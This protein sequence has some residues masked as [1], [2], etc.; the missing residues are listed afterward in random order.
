MRPR[1]ILAILV[2]FLNSACISN[3]YS[4]KLVTKSKEAISVNDTKKALSLLNNALL[5]NS[6]NGEA[7]L[8]KGKIYETINDTAQ[9]IKEYIKAHKYTANSA[10][11][12]IEIGRLLYEIGR[13]DE[14]LKY[15]TKSFEEDSTNQQTI[16]L[17]MLV[18]S[19]TGQAE[20]AMILFDSHAT[21]D[22]T[23]H[24]YAKAVASDTLGMTDYAAIFY[25][26]TIEKD[27]TN[28]Q[29]YINYSQLLIDIGNDQAALETANEG[30]MLFNNTE[31]I[32]KTL[33]IHTSKYMWH[34]AIADA[35][36]LYNLT[37]NIEYIEKRARYFRYLGLLNNARNDYS[38]IIA[39]DENNTNALF[40]RAIINMR[41][42]NED[43]VINDLN[44]FMKLETPQT[45]KWQLDRVKEIVAL[46]SKDIPPPIITITTPAQYHD[47]YVGVEQK[48]DS[49]AIEGTIDEHA[50]V[51]S[52]TLNDLEAQIK[53]KNDYKTFNATIPF[54]NNDTICIKSTDLYD[55]NTIKNYQITNYENVKPEVLLL[56]PKTD[57]VGNTY[58]PDNEREIKIKLLAADNNYIGKIYINNQLIESHVNKRTALIDTAIATPANNKVKITVS[59]IF[60]NAATKEF[61]IKN[62]DTIQNNNTI[63]KDLLAIFINGHANNTTSNKENTSI[64]RKIFTSAENANIETITNTTKKSVERYLMFDLSKKISQHQ[65]NDI[66]IYL[67]GNTA[68]SQGGAYWLPDNADT[69]NK[70]T[71]LNLLLVSSIIKKLN[72]KGTVAVITNNIHLPQWNDAENA[73]TNEKK[74]YSFALKTK[75]ECDSETETG[76]WCVLEGITKVDFIKMLENISAQHPEKHAGIW[77]GSSHHYESNPM[78]LFIK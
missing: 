39:C 24:I 16:Y 47:K 61:T 22:N 25:R 69:T 3:F 28:R 73:A 77:L 6:K 43:D 7:Y 59:D 66:V 45:P 38:F 41:L 2:S 37:H 5:I 18:L 32:K 15:L 74:A 40:E 64:L 36:T 65:Y 8:L 26:K 54:P 1:L 56:L 27:K 17:L 23:D 70:Q 58:I 44:V 52:I 78:I 60:G 76:E 71:W 42:N 31:L 50:R 14:S 49:L 48:G 30:I 19:A 46:L 68:I 13:Y 35:T 53:I 29:A 55:N 10:E 33:A 12:G 11:I 20:N 63:D 21:P 75:I 62:I 51:T 9:A 72:N 67:N 34:N 57:T 4:H